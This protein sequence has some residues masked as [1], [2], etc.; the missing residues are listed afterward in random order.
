MNLL[1]VLTATGHCTFKRLNQVSIFSAMVADKSQVKSHVPPLF[2]SHEILMSEVL[3][4]LFSNQTEH[5]VKTKPT[6]KALCH[7]NPGH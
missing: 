3:F 2:K 1:L 4:Q 5:T 6:E 7:Q